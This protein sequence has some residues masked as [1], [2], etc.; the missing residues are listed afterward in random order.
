MLQFLP[1]VFTE[2]LL[3]PNEY[4]YTMPPDLIGALTTGISLATAICLL[5]ILYHGLCVFP[6]FHQSINFQILSKSAFGQWILAQGKVIQGDKSGNSLNLTGSNIDVSQGKDDEME[7]VKTKTAL[8][9]KLQRLL[10][11]EKIFKDIRSSFD[12]EKFFQTAV[13]QIGE[14]FKV[15]RCLVHIYLESPTPHIPLVAEYKRPEITEPWVIDV[16]VIGNPHVVRILSQDAAIVCHDVDKE[17]L[18]KD[19]LHLCHQVGLKS[20]VGV[21]TSYQG[22]PNGMIG[23]HQY[24]YPRQW[25]DEEISLL[26]AVAGQLGI[27]IAQ[28][29]LLTME[30]Q[31]RIELDWHNKQLSEEIRIRQYTEEALR[32]SE[33]RWQLVLNGNNDGIYD[34]DITTGYAFLSTRIK[35]M[36]GY[37]DSDLINHVDTWRNLLHPEDFQRVIASQKAYLEKKSPQ[38]L[39][40]YR[41]RCKDGNYKWILARGQALWD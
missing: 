21:R 37:E 15:D 24:H 28:A 19:S 32:K 17:P 20:M 35:T 6:K 27:A 14:A 13:N 33:Q 8:E 9:E 41:L 34:W 31:R 29:N 26:E 39:V 40:E 10:I 12:P 4:C 38:Y 2:G 7:F 36:L 22:K 23:I 3:N 30:R 18:L 5:W 1:S 25:L 16:P 11:Q